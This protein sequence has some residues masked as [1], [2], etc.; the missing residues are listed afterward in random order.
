MRK[1]SAGKVDEQF[2]EWTTLARPSGPGEGTPI[3]VKLVE[4]IICQKTLFNL[5]VEYRTQNVDI[6]TCLEQ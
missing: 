5:F 3:R 4:T 1:S 6:E 2:P